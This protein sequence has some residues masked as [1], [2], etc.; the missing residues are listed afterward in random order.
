MNIDE[1]FIEQGNKNANGVLTVGEAIF[2]YYRLRSGEHA[3]RVIIKTGDRIDGDAICRFANGLTWIRV[4]K[5]ANI[6]CERVGVSFSESRHP[7]DRS[8]ATWYPDNSDKP[9]AH[10]W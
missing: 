4:A 8:Q 1:F 5:I 6:L 10:E 9:M 3:G 2:G 7:I